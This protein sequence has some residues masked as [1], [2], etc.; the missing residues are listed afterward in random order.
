MEASYACRV[1]LCLP[2][3]VAVACAAP[4]CSLFVPKLQPVKIT[5]TDPT[6][7]ILVNGKSVGTGTVAVQLERNKGHTVVAKADGKTGA[8]AINR[9]IST[10]G[11]LDIVGGIFLLVPFLGLLGPGFW[12]L[13]PDDVTVQVQ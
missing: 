9:K 12:E 8:A 7:E 1:A 3:A 10:T 13:D 5:A 6:A 2:L 11:V 4:G